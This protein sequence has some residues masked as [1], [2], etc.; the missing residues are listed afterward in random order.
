[1]KFN[2]K[3]N[4]SE[5]PGNVIGR[6]IEFA[7]KRAEEFADDISDHMVKISGN[8]VTPDVSNEEDENKWTV[9]VDNPKQQEFAK[10]HNVV[11]RTYKGSKK[12]F[13]K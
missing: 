1:M 5:T 10:R 3:L 11:T 12:I 4:P 2:I 6:A 8:K 13:E 9:V 7:K